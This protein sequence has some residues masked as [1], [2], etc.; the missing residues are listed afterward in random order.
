MNSKITIEWFM[1][2]TCNG[3]Y[4]WEDYYRELAKKAHSAI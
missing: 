4:D 2:G 3:R 1:G